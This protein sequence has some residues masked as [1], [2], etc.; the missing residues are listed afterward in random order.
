MRILFLTLVCL[1]TAVN[2][3][4]QEWEAIPYSQQENLNGISIIHPDTA[5]VVSSGGILS[6]TFDG[7]QTWKSWMVAKGTSLEDVHFINSQVG[8]I[9]GGRGLLMITTDGGVHWA[10]KDITDTTSWF[11]DVEMLDKTHGLVIGTAREKDTPMTGLAFRTADAGRTWVKQ[12]TIGAGYAEIFYKPGNPVYFLSFGKINYSKDM[13]E[14][15]EWFMTVDGS[16]ARAMSL[17]GSSGL[18]CGMDGMSAF[19]RDGGYNWSSYQH[20]NATMFIAAQLIDDTT[21]YIGGTG[22]VVMKT[23]D[24]GRSW[25]PETLPRPFDVFDFFLIEDKLWAVGSHGSV[26]VKK[27]K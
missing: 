7:G 22:G 23:T 16:P 12:E 1:L 26:A 21:G 6:R 20:N 11:F 2:L 18:I 5:F 19:T 13:G 14:T 3:Y 8:W 15:W 24:G 4:A 25:T 27:V 9:C 17:Y 10:K